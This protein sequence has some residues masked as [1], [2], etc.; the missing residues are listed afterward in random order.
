MTRLVP[1]EHVKPPAITK[2]GLVLPG[3]GHV[4]T[5]DWSIG[6]GLLGVDAW[7]L[8]AAIAGG[9]R[10]QQIIGMG[11]GQQTSLHG[12]LAVGG[13][14]GLLGGAWYLAW[15]KVN[16][17]PPDPERANS[18]WGIFARELR[19]NRNGMIGLAMVVQLMVF[20]L[21]APMFAPFDPDAVDAGTKLTSPTLTYLM[22]TDEFGRDMFSRVALGARV[23]VV[24]G[25]IAVG[26]AGT[27]G[28]A[29]GAI[30]GFFGGVVDR[31]LMW[32]VD[33]L[34]AVPRLVL[35]LAIVGLFRPPGVMAIF[36][37][38]VVLGLTGWMSVA[39]IVRSQVLSLKEQDFVQ[40]AR[41][42]GMRS[43]RI[44]LRHLI[45]NAIAPVIVYGSL[46]I[47]TT[48]LAEASLSFLGLGVQPPTSTWGTLVA[49]GRHKLQTAPWIAIWPGLAIVYAVTSFNLLGDGLRD[50]LDPKQR[51]QG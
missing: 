11:A 22:G 13:W 10:I 49:D 25:F 39:R 29:V 45:P 1:H 19:R 3:L 31:T 40:A 24:I 17:A 51:G 30:A 12:I 33:L 8:W 7:L 26:I 16:P 21:L 28:T 14:V 32:V 50:A 34:L 5:G 41:A 27:V 43:S 9:P 37:I 44:I 20:T 36:V 35:L 42:L 2:A 48:M 23:S 47:G 18:T 6:L 15:L 46:A 38:V 4:L